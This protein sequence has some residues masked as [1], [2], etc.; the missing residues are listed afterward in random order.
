[1]ARRSRIVAENRALSP[2]EFR[3][4]IDLLREMEDHDRTL[5]KHNVSLRTFLDHRRAKDGALPNFR[6][7]VAGEQHF[8]HTEEEVRAIAAEIASNR[9]SQEIEDGKAVLNGT[10]T[11]TEIHETR[12]I[13]R[14]LAKLERRGFP[15]ADYYPPLDLDPETPPRYRLDYEGE[16]LGLHS[17]SEIAPAVRKAGEKGIQIQRYKGLGEM[18][19]DQLGVTTMSPDSRTLLRVRL[20]DAVEAEKLFSLL[21]GEGVAARREFIEKHALEATNLDI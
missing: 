21:M 19:P 7:S 18:N 12:D 3:E 20:E 1:M 8:A 14:S 10:L 15:A 6:I 17:V 5:R 16:S 2:S 13:E 9:D 4:L 11:V